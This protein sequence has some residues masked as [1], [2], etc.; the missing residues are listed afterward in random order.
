M[1][2]KEF[3]QTTSINR[4]NTLH[5]QLTKSAISIYNSCIKDRI[6]LH[7]IC[8]RRTLEEQTT[9]Y[10][11]GRTIPGNILTTNRPGYSAHNH[12]LALDFCFFYDGRMQ[13][14]PDAE[15]VEYWRWMWIKVV[16]RF[17]EEGWSTG[18]RRQHNYEPGH[19][20]NLLDKTLGQWYTE[21][22]GEI[23]SNGIKH[24]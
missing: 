24:L 19:V 4:I 1:T 20:E 15:K 12:G 3:T 21:S 18:F 5:P 14:W 23:R 11:Y 6:P 9:I 8:G 17:E 2:T 22:Y 16:K 10:K 13:T 7:I